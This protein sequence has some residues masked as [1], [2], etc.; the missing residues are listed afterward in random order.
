MPE[1]EDYIHHRWHGWGFCCYY[2]CDEASDLC[3]PPFTK[4]MYSTQTSFNCGPHY[5]RNP[6]LFERRQPMPP[7]PPLHKHHRSPLAGPP[8]PPHHDEEKDPFGPHLRPETRDD[9]LPSP[10]R[11]RL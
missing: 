8:R 6:S 5:P 2:A 11:H 10:H 9:R 1:R 7:P 3:A 4:Q